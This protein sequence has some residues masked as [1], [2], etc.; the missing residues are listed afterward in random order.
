MSSDPHTRS[1]IPCVVCM[2]RRDLSVHVVEMGN[3]IAAGELFQETRHFSVGVDH[4][5]GMTAYTYEP[6]LSYRRTVSSSS[7]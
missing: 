7:W 4:D 3:E 2:G 1:W 6:D 5:G